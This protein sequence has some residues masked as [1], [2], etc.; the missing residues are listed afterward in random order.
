[1]LEGGPRRQDD[2]RVTGRVGD[3]EIVDHGEKIGAGQ[4]GGDQSLFRGPDDGVGVVDN[5]R[6][7]RRI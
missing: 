4:T 3:E 2:V 1:M 5:Q 6:L 7:D